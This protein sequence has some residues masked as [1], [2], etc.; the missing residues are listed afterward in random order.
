MYQ[1]YLSMLDRAGPGECMAL[2]A[3]STAVWYGLCLAGGTTDAVPATRDEVPGWLLFWL[4]GT[5]YSV[6]VLFRY[7][8]PA[9]GAWRGVVVGFA[10]ALSYWMGV[11][12]PVL[13]YPAGSEIF[14][15]ATAGVFT[16]AFLGYLVMRLGT[17]RFALG[18]FAALCVAGGFG[19]AVI[20]W[21]VTDGWPDQQ[22]AGHAVWQI[23]TCVAFYYSPRSARPPLTEI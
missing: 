18:S 5:V 21:S 15:T 16:A 11:Q 13:I 6:L 8:Q 3:L 9:A 20:G 1:R 14:N 22:V 23:L 12:Y 19:G 2:A 17:L 10:G 4:S 7:L